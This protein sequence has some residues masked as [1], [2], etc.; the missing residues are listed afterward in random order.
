MQAIN[1]QVS[2]PV[3]LRE[4]K[5]HLSKVYALSHVSILVRTSSDPA[6]IKHFLGQLSVDSGLPVDHLEA[7]VCSLIPREMGS[8]WL[9]PRK[10]ETAKAKSRSRTRQPS[11]ESRA[12]LNARD[13]NYNERSAKRKAAFR[14]SSFF[15]KA[16]VNRVNRRI[17]IR[18][19]KFCRST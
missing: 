6:E 15:E 10:L 4:L 12:N 14:F 17:C 1:G 8:S 16:F 19:V 9:S 18:I 11:P 2:F 13:R 5:Q 3:K 7:E